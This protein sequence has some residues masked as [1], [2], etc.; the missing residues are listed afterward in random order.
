[1]SRTQLFAAAL[2]AALLAPV[3]SAQSTL[4]QSTLAQSLSS[5]SSLLRSENDGATPAP[6][7]D[8]RI[9]G[10]VLSGTLRD[11]SGQP[12]DGAVVIL[13]QRG[14]EIARTTTDRSGRYVINELQAGQYVVVSGN[15]GRVVRLWE[16]AI[17]PPAAQ[18]GASLTQPQ[19]GVTRGNPLAGFGMSTLVSATAITGAAVGVGLGV[20]AKDDVEH[21]EHQNARLNSELQSL[22]EQVSRSE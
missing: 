14:V 20:S 10:G 12:V 22:R 17:A 3:A 13:G 11:S 7:T 16:T 4:A 6:V 9:S 5:Q 1:M 19:A 15:V 2:C 18:P 21:L 8:V